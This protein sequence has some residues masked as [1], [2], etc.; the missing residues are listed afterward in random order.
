MITHSQHN[1]YCIS[2]KVQY[3]IF[4]LNYFFI[5]PTAPQ[6]DGDPTLLFSS[7]F[8]TGILISCI[9]DKM[10]LRSPALTELIF[11]GPV[12]LGF[13]IFHKSNGTLLNCAFFYHLCHINQ[14]RKKYLS[15]AILFFVVNI[16]KILWLLLFL[17][18]EE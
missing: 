6:S 18:G 14:N 15:L 16:Q 7:I 9:G 12:V 8:P 10:L 4:N 3:S 5:H 13:F 2:H 1:K 17:F 11:T